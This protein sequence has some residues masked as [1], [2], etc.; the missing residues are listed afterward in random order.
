VFMDDSVRKKRDR[1]A[2]GTNEVFLFYLMY[3]L[4]FYHMLCSS[5]FLVKMI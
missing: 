3:L 2:K 5:C 1:S 4:V